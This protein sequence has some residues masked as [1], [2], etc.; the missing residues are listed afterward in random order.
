MESR[1][2]TI[3]IALLNRHNVDYSYAINGCEFD[4][5]ALGFSKQIIKILEREINNDE[6]EQS[7]TGIYV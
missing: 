2:K 4:G 5:E 3:Y 7:N 6:P 1:V